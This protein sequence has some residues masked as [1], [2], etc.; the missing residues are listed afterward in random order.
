MQCLGGF[1]RQDQHPF[2]GNHFHMQ[3]GFENWGVYHRIPCNEFIW[4]AIMSRPRGRSNQPCA[5]T[6]PVAATTRKCDLVRQVW[7]PAKQVWT[8][9]K[10]V[11]RHAKQV[12]MPAETSLNACRKCRQR[13]SQRRSP[14]KKAR[15]VCARGGSRL[16]P[17]GLGKTPAGLSPG[18]TDLFV[19][20]VARKR[21]RVIPFP[22]GA[23]PPRR[24]LH[25]PRCLMPETTNMTAVQENRIIRCWPG[26]DYRFNYAAS[27]NQRH[28]FL[29]PA[30]GSQISELAPVLAMHLEVFR[31][32]AFS[33]ST[34]D[35]SIG[36]AGMTR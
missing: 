28:A 5:T 32:A 1:F 16:F 2:A 22:P 11:W 24:R 12:W 23:R 19:E 27:R 9:A 17:P 13:F 26:Y 20:K 10:Q 34:S 29:W 15:R 18:Q 21:N 31:L 14:Q 36:L 6:S 7:M 25:H 8:P 30:G 33:T 4:N 3:V 35:K